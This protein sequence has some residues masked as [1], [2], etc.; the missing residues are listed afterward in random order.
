M[1]ERN[2]R[3][4]SSGLASSASLALLLSG[5]SLL[6][7]GGASAGGA[8]AM[9]TDL[10]ARH[11]A[12]DE[13]GARVHAALLVA[14]PG[15]FVVGDDQLRRFVS[16]TAAS[17]IGARRAGL[18]SRLANAQR[19]AGALVGTTYLGACLQDA[20]DEPPHGPLGLLAEAW[21]FRRILIAAAIPGGRRIGLWLDGTFLYTE[22]GFAALDLER[23]E[24]PRWEHSDLDIA[25]CDMATH[26]H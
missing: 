10:D 6:G 17:R 23:L 12:I 16:S 15:D 7:C 9:P 20:G 3:A 21:T 24:D 2:G 8:S 19:T 22:A 1:S 26:L 4:A 25:P 18:S 5:A 14:A 11:A 13:F